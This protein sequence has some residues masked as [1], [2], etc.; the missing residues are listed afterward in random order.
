M[1]VVSRF[2]QAHGFIQTELR[3]IGDPNMT[4]C[5]N[6][7]QFYVEIDKRVF[8]KNYWSVSDCESDDYIQ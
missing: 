8:G 5:C 3:L 7:A 1:K 2:D 6:F 4:Y